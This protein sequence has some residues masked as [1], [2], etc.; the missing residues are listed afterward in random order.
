MEVSYEDLLKEP[1]D[2]FRTVFD[3]LAIDAPV[4]EGFLDVRVS[5]YS[6]ERRERGSVHSW[7]NHRKE[8]SVLLGGVERLLGGEIEML[9]YGG[10][11]SVKPNDNSRKRAPQPKRGSKLKNTAK[12][13]R[14]RRSK[15]KTA[16][17][18]PKKL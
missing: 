3:F 2:A 16:A 5:Q 18:E 14:T 12:K 10:V 13:K 11:P 8:Y 7:R 9:G 15:K 6:E 4:A 17:P 1:L